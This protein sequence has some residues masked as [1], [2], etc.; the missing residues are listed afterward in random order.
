MANRPGISVR[1]WDRW[2]QYVYNLFSSG[3]HTS[4][5]W[6][7][8]S[9]PELDHFVDPGQPM[10]IPDGFSEDEENAI[11]MVEVP[12]AVLPLLRGLARQAGW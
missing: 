7:Y 6:S 5:I 9:G 10:Q 4:P 3:S 8:V 1:G 12:L 2:A 11:G